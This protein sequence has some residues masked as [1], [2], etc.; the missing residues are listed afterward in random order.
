M[1]SDI[2]DLTGEK[3]GHWTV[4][5]DAGRA[6]NNEVMWKCQC[7][8]G[9]IREVRGAK[10]RQGKSQS[11][12]CTTEKKD[13]SG[14]KFG[15]WK[16]IRR[17]RDHL[18]VAKWLCRNGKVH[19]MLDTAQLKKGNIM[20][21]SEGPGK[22][23]VVGRSGDSIRKDGHEWVLASRAPKKGMI[24]AECKSTGIVTVFDQAE[25]DTKNPPSNMSVQV[26]SKKVG[27][28]DL[29]GQMFSTWKVLHREGCNKHGQA[30]WE[31]E[32]QK[33]GLV[34]TIAGFAVKRGTGCRNCNK[35]F[36]KDS[37]KV[38]ATNS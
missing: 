22:W 23:K 26:A 30:T 13:I 4:L 17:T 33:C 25:F 9:T 21:D 14:K 12:G 32:C 7:T 19:A 6:S 8:C 18:N 36:G 16:V 24:V 11:C 35:L 27:Y 10:I 29:S 15:K 2:K 31:C 5:E 28:E 20:P 38:R 3:I 1:Y 34:K 37:H